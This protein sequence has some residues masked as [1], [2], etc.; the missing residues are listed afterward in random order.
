MRGESFK[1]LQAAGR[2]KSSV[3]PAATQFRRLALTAMV[4]GLA[5]VLILL[6]QFSLIYCNTELINFGVQDA[7][8]SLQYAEPSNYTGDRLTEHPTDEP[9]FP[10]SSVRVQI[11]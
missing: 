4:Q 11:K 5:F 2:R 6:S 3:M 8:S 10:S 9:N 1:Y 7:V